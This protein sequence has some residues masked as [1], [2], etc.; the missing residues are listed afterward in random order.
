MYYIVPEHL[1]GEIKGLS[2]SSSSYKQ[3]RH[4]FLQFSYL[5]HS[6]FCISIFSFISDNEIN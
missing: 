3:I 2:Y 1:Q 6:I 5:L 4:V